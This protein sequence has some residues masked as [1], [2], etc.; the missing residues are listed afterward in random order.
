MGIAEYNKQC[1]AIVMRYSAEWKVSRT[2]QKD[3]ARLGFEVGLD[4]NG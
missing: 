2:L 1:R 3:N 4:R